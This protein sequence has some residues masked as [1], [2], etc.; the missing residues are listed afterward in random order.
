MDAG[1][2]ARRY[3][4]VL[5]DFA[6][7]RGKLDEVYADAR[8][9]REALGRQ[10]QA[11]K[12]FDSPLRKPSEKRAFVEAVF[13][14]RVA[15]ETLRFLT[16]LVDKERIGHVCGILRVFEMLYKR[17]RHIC[18]ANITTARELDEERRARF[19]ALVADKVRSSGETVASVDATF[20]A[21]P[22]II[23]GVVLAIDGRQVDGSVKSKLQ[24]VQR[25]LTV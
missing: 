6:A 5:H 18:T 23:G 16:F 9:V 25:Q 3:A 10:P 19:V 11:Q 14:G 8:V 20:R 7:D 22:R 12:L 13:G 24:A 4:T 1:L 21:D 15:E 2:I 17:E